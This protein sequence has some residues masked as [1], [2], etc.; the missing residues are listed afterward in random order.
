M[1]GGGG[2]DA[3]LKSATGEKARVKTEMIYRPT[4]V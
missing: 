2:S 3:S 1:G 4:P